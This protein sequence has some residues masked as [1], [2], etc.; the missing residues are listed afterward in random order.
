MSEKK[1][2]IMVAGILI[3]LGIVMAQVFQDVGL[4]LWCAIIGIFLSFGLACAI[5]K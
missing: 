5:E 2:D 4:P 1:T 3:V